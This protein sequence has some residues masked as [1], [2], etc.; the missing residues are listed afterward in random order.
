MKLQIAF[1]LTN[2]EH[3]LTLARQVHDFVDI[4]EVGTLLVYKHGD[5]AVTAFRKEF[6]T[7]TILADCKIADRTK[8]AVSLFANAGADW[9][10]VMAGS[11]R[12]V[13]HMASTHA[14][15]QGK[16]VML[17]LLD[18]SSLGQSAL[19]AKSLGVDALLFHK[20]A[21]DDA[22]L[23]FLDRWDMVKGNT[24]LPVFVS[25]SFSPEAATE[26]LAINPYG[27]VLSSSSYHSDA[28]LLEHVAFIRSLLE[29]NK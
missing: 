13:I 5:A 11:G 17:D 16:K 6:P 29:Q 10:T 7:K 3:A 8:E 14:H 2:I 19:E 20:P 22:Q 1:D 9:I 24:S 27:I 25:A 28:E 26:L 15:E 21:D 4:L 23:T 12:N 18:A